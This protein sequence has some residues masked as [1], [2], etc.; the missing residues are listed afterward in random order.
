MAAYMNQFSVS[1]GTT[2][3]TIL[4]APAASTTR[5]VGAGCINIVNLDT[6]DIVVT[7]QVNDN[8]TNRVQ[9]KAITIPPSDSWS[10]DKQIICLDA[11]TQTL[12]IYLAGAVAA[13]EADISVVYRDILQ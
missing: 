7:L 4:A 3:V 8:T 13:T 2:D 12:E 9:E 5:M 1:N 10:N 11:T 6:S